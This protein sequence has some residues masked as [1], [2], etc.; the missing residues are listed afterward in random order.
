MKSVDFCD[1][2][3]GNS[4]ESIAQPDAP[5]KKN[6]RDY[7]EINFTKSASSWQAQE[8]NFKQKALGFHSRKSG[9]FDKNQI[10]L[11]SSRFQ[12]RIIAATKPP[13]NSERIT[14][15]LQMAR[16]TATTGGNRL[17]RP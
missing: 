10:F 8:S 3:Q 2:S 15:L 9:A 1:S 11:R 14:F 17:R 16:M 13:Q 6:T 5:V 4:E 12:I 7:T